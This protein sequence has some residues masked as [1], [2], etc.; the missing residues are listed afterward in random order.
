MHQITG[1]HTVVL[2]V[3]YLQTR[4]GDSES[5]MQ[6]NL[7]VRPDI[8]MDEFIYQIMAAIKLLSNKTLPTN[9]NSATLSLLDNRPLIAEK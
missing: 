7:L 1:W 5:D 9:F 6:W 3:G 8:T 2:D 4:T